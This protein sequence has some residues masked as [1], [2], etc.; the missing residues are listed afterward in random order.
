[1][2]IRWTLRRAT[3]VRV[4]HARATIRHCPSAAVSNKQRD[5]DTVTT[6]TPRRDIFPITTTT[7]KTTAVTCVVRRACVLY[8]Y[9]YTHTYGVHDYYYYYRYYKSISFF[10]TKYPSRKR[11][12]IY[13]IFNPLYTTAGA[14]NAATRCAYDILLCRYRT[15]IT[16]VLRHTLRMRRGKRCNNN[17][18]RREID[19]RCD[20]DRQQRCGISFCC[21]FSDRYFVCVTRVLGAVE[22]L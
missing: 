8:I 1:M 12:I 21:R 10:K 14:K 6:P 2:T 20:V 7:T 18:C 13:Y 16:Y 5:D 3:R 11:V 4:S 17:S 19:I 22:T 9:I 15:Y